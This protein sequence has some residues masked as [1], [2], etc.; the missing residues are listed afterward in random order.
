M[1]SD[2]YIVFNHPCFIKENKYNYADNNFL[3][4]SIF[5]QS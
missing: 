3:E 1:L 5:S 2:K 4:I